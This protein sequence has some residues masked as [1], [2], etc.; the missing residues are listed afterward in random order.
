LKKGEKLRYFFGLDGKA[1]VVT[2]KTGVI[3]ACRK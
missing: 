3:G 2:A 1:R